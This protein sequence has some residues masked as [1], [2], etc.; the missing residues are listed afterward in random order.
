[1]SNAGQ[2]IQ[3]ASISFQ[4]QVAAQVISTSL[5]FLAIGAIILAAGL[6]LYSKN[7]KEKGWKK[8]L[9]I[10]LLLA[11]LALFIYWVVGVIFALIAPAVTNT[12]ASGS[13]V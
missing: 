6:F 3:N 4:K 8:T 12:I 9:W 10:L 5:P 7:K 1:M 11:G 2:A 13:G